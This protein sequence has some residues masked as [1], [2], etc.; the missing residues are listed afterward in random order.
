VQ[1]LPFTGERF[2]PECVREI[3]YEHVHRYAL[4]RHL[5]GGKRVLDIACGEG[6]GAAIVAPVAKSV[7]G[8]DVSAEA[9][10]HARARYGLLPNLGFREGDATRVD[11]GGEQFDLVLSFETLEHVAEQDALVAGL[12]RA[13]APG[14]FAMIS[15]PDKAEY[16]DASGQ[17]NEFHVR[18]LYRD[19]LL[20]LLGRHFRVVRLCAQRLMFHSAIWALDAGRSAVLAQTAQP[21]G[22]FD[23]D[24]FGKPMYYVALCAQHEQD[25]PVLPGLAL[26]A[27][28]G[29]SVYAHYHHEIRKNMQAGALLAEREQALLAAA[30][31]LARAEARV[32]ELEAAAAAKPA[33]SRF[34]P[35]HRH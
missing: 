26:F 16:S 4:A 33:R 2:T 30:A 25:L 3:W 24:A 14:G 34:W 13:L 8:V 32:R 12:S 17:C 22:R 6:Y 31:N 35:F 28:A 15:S 23:T 21:D 9:I 18:E 5:A 20:E 7:L 19:E 10:G 11:L 1:E 29:E 27:D